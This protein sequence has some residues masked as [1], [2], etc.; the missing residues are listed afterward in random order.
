MRNIILAIL[1][2][3]SCGLQGCTVSKTFANARQDV[4][5]QPRSEQV[6]EDAKE[7]AN[8]NTDANNG[9][10]NSGSAVSL[11]DSSHSITEKDVRVVMPIAN[12]FGSA[13]VALKEI[14]N[15]EAVDGIRARIEADSTLTDDQKKELLDL[16][17]VDDLDNLKVKEVEITRVDPE[18]L[19]QIEE[20]KELARQVSDQILS[21]LDNLLTEYTAPAAG[22]SD[23]AVSLSDHSSSITEKNVSVVIP[24]AN[25]FGASI[26][27]DKGKNDKK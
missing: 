27:T 21:A 19:R 24:I 6:K 8:A 16:T 7:D 25:S 23:N 2:A 13:V 12:S 9:T 22:N 5:L 10:G 17:E 3:A 4:D 20:N 11:S 15:E 14:G 18:L 1:V 26:V